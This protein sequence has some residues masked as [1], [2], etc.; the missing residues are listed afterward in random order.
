MT[1]T[2]LEALDAHQSTRLLRLSFP[3]NNGMPAWEW[4]VAVEQPQFTMTTQ[5]DETDDD[6]CAGAAGWRATATGSSTAEIPPS[7]LKKSIV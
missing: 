1:M 4:E 5:W 7:P 3:M 6:T 2:D